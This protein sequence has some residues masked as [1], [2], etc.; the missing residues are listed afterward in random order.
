MKP[1]SV[2]NRYEAILC[3]FAK[4]TGDNASIFAEVVKQTRLA[5]PVPTSRDAEI[6]SV[7]SG[8]AGPVLCSYVLWVL[9]QSVESG[10]KR[11]YFVSRDGEILIEIARRL[12]PTFWPNISMDFRYLLG[13]RQAWMLPSFVVSKSE[14]APYLLRFLENSSLKTIFARVDL[15]LQDCEP[16]LLKHGFTA[17]D[18]ERQLNRRDFK[19]VNSLVLDGDIQER[20]TLRAEQHKDITLGYFEQ[21]GLFD[22]VPYGLVDLGWTGSAKGALEKILGIRGK[23]APPFFMFGRT[24]DHSS[25]DPSALYTYH[26]NID[27][28]KSIAVG[29]YRNLSAIYVLIEMFCASL[30]DGLNRYEYKDD[31]YV[32]LLRASTH[33]ALKEWGFQTMRDS[34]LRFAEILAV[35][36]SRLKSPAYLSPEISDAL[37]RAF[38][39]TPTKPEALVWG[40]FPFEED[41][42]S[43][44]FHRLVPSIEPETFWRAF[45]TGNGFRPFCVWSRGIF[46]VNPPWVRFFWLLAMAGYRIRKAMGLTN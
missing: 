13:S 23:S 25:D 7:C 5:S 37:L 16:S 15:A 29:A 27:E 35:Q 46:A 42:N 26:F 8:V 24:T 18:W 45:Q 30:S 11:L 2:F 44:T 34:I 38:W 17:G 32:P 14:I 33:D 41:P 31:R 9:S 39:R 28:S 22:D 6:I 36:S 19:S 20:I 3:S 1:N 43:S 40:Q 4:E 21:E 10:L 12:F